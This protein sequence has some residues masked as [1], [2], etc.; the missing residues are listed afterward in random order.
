MASQCTAF[1]VSDEKKCDAT[2]TSLN[3]PFCRFHSKQC[4]GLYKGYKRRNTA[5]DALDAS[6]PAYLAS[7]R[8]PLRN[9]MFADASDGY[10][11]NELHTYL[12]KKH[13]LR[14]RVIRAR[15][16]HHSRFFSLNM[17]YGHK[18][19]LDKLAND[20]ITVLRALERLERRTAEVLYCQQKWF[21]W[22]RECQDE[23]ESQRENEAKKIKREAQLFK[24][25]WREV[26][27]RVKNARRQENIKRQEAYLDELYQQRMAEKSEEEE[28]DEEWDPIEDAIEDERSNFVD[29][30]RHLLWMPAPSVDSAVHEEASEQGQ[31]TA[32]AS[33][34]SA[35][36]EN[37][38][39][40]ASSTTVA[41]KPADDAKPSQALS[42]SAKK[43]AKA[44]AK[45]QDAPDA[46][47][48]TTEG[49][50]VEVNETKEQMR[51]RLLQGAEYDE[52]EGI[53]G[54]LVF[55][56]IENPVELMGKVPG[57][58]AGEV[59]ALLEQIAEIKLLL[60]CR[61]LLSQ[62][63]L[64]PAALRANSVGEFLADEEVTTADLRDLCLRIEQPG[65]QQIRDA[66]ADLARGNG[67][68]EAYESQNEEEGLEN[69]AASKRPHRRGIGCELMEREKSKRTYGMQSMRSLP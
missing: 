48:P 63:A 41:A 64:L 47:V 62:A 31:S 38:D 10:T 39:P 59:D 34:S 18:S 35:D 66:C 29:M 37:I 58:P 49:P 32:A 5:L 3:G 68:V 23:E 1:N 60:F 26:E 53:Y 36:K 42:K 9:E 8:T 27:T 20:K 52:K 2:A 28:D 54:P 22:V 4:Q 6:P 57:M 7:R 45:Q 56:T 24:R 25:H 40:A 46:T 11:L 16:L 33:M 61:M 12:F 69:E 17:D 30:M 44:R 14:D 15:K 19:Y 51:E 50:K 65:L 55:G 43:R 13:A 67:E 21:K